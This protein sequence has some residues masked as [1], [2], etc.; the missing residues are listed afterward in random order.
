MLLPQ[1][2]PFGEVV[3]LA[4]EQIAKGATVYQK[5]TCAGC[6]TRQTMEKANVFYTEGRCEEC[7]TITDLQETGCGFLLMLSKGGA[8]REA[9]TADRG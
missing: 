5:F 9:D 3:R 7:G 6:G 4:D 1:N 2:K 8:S